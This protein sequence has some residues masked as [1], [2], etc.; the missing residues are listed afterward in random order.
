MQV[1]TEPD[2]AHLPGETTFYFSYVYTDMAQQGTENIS[3]Q[4]IL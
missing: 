1:T 2:F 3:Y 4:V